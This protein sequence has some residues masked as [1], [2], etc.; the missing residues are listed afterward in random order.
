MKRGARP[1]E[2]VAMHIRPTAI[3][4]EDEGG[5]EEPRPA[6]SRN[7]LSFSAR[8]E[9]NQQKNKKPASSFSPGS[10]G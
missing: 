10:V 6:E 8:E 1:S 7:R 9:K 5:D 4:D 3:V 2:A